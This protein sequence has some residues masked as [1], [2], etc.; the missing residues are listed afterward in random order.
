MTDVAQLER[1]RDE[2]EAVARKWSQR[3]QVAHPPAMFAI[4]MLADERAWVR[5]VAVIVAASWALILIRSM[6][7]DRAEMDAWRR[8]YHAFYR[9][10]LSP[11]ALDEREARS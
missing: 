9:G 10:Q 7:A 4:V 6:R 2:A 5:V 8:W 3:E 1:L 11:T